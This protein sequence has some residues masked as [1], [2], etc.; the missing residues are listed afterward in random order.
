MLS[1][2]KRK[3]VHLEEICHHVETKSVHELVYSNQ[4]GGAHIKGVEGYYSLFLRRTLTRF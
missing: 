3:E 4:S 1:P 2:P